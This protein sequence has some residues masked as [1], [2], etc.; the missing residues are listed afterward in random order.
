MILDDSKD[1]TTF[2][3]LYGRY[4]FNRMPFGISSASEVMQKKGYQMFGDIPGIHI[5]ADDMLIAGDTEEEHD[6]A[7]T[8]VLERAAE[9]NIKFSLPKLQF[10]KPQVVYHGNSLLTEGIQADKSK[11][12]AVQNMPD[13][14]DKQGVQRFLGMV[15]YL[16]PF[17]PNKAELTEPLRQ[18]VKDGIPFTWG[19]AQ[20]EATKRIKAVLSSQ[21]IL[22]HYD[23]N[24]PL[25]I[26]ADASQDGLGACLLQE[27]QPT[28]YA[29]RSMTDTEKRYAQIKKEML[30]IVFATQK[31]R[32]YI[33]GT[34][35]TVHSDHKPLESIQY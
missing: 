30:A 17:V 19:R 11:V 18:L 32:H 10:K 28:S 20:K 9:N 29:S 31:F 1:L 21:V 14:T 8:K 5:I 2:Q 22:R 26:Q 27:G 15:N 16:S 4:R 3:T 24:K 25:T 34:D 12:E 6:T 23:E 35:V 33:Y 13:P 7:V